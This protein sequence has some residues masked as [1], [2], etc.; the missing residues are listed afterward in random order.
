MAPRN[1]SDTENK[2]LLLHAID[3]LDAVTTHQ[4]LLFM[5]ENNLMDY[6]SLQLLLAELM[7]AGLLRKRTHAIGALYSPT[8]EGLDSLEMFRS[9]VP[10]SRLAAVDDIAE[11]W[12][13]R[14]RREKQ[15]LSQFSEEN[16]EFVVRLRLLE[17]DLDLLDIRLTVPTHKQA[18]R[19][20]DAWIAQAP[21]IYAHLMHSL[22]EGDT[23]P[24]S[25]EQ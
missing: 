25:K 9:R 13:L 1:P 18:Q 19:F 17:W 21:N 7:D 12:R 20:C 5:V 24:T 14:F 15:M 22:G 2:L 23:A 16:G 3:R 4:I 11:A 6:I 8:R 10:H